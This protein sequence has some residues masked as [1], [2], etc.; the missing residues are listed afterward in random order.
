MKVPI[1]T[2][3]AMNIA[4]ND[5]ASNDHVALAEDLRSIHRMH[6]R[7]VP[8]SLVVD[9]LLGDA[10]ESA[11]DNSVALTF[12][13][14]SWFDWHDIEHPDFG[15]QRGFAGILRD[16]G[17]QTGAP[18]QATSFV[19][20]SP[21]AR[22]TLD[23]TCMVGRGW[24]GDEWWP[25]AVREGLLAIESHSWDHN[26]STLPRTAQRDGQTGTFATI[27]THVEADLEI[28]QANDWLDAHLP[29]RKSSLF[30]YPYGDSNDYLVKKYL[31]DHVAEHRLRAAFG[32]EPRPLES[33]SNRWLLPRYVCGLH[34][35]APDAL[36]ALLRGTG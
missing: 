24:W 18:A 29:M 30:A 6:L 16:F 23:R 21:E 19:I 25:L 4:G 32:G 35:H 36:A 31:P 28:R 20:V 7:I 27:E 13:D 12:D 15:L 2:Y 14:G 1:L 34:W 17:A 8:L 10:P 22:A 5:Y 11:V 3:H 9:A 33:S 26:H